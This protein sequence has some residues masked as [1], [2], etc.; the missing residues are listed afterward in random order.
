MNRRPLLLSAIGFMVLLA[1]TLILVRPDPT[2]EDAPYFTLKRRLPDTLTVAHGPDTTV[3]VPGGASGWE[4][5]RPVRYPADHLVAETMLKRLADIRVARTYPLT[6]EKMD[7]YGMRISR[8][9]IVAAYAD[10]L[11]SDTLTIGAFTLNDSY[12]YIRAGSRLE[13]GLMDARLVRSFLLKSTLEL[14]D[15]RLMPFHETRADT[16]QLLGPGASVRVTLARGAENRWELLAP[17]NAPVDQKKARNFLSSVG[18]MNIHRFVTEGE[19]GNLQDF[20]LLDPRAGARVVTRNGDV[21]SVWLGDDLPAISD[22][23][24]EI[25]VAAKSDLRPHLLGVSPKYLEVLRS[26]PEA[27]ADAAPFRFGLVSVDA[28]HLDAPG[29]SATFVW[30]DSIG[31]A[32]GIRDVFRNWIVLRAESFDR[33]SPQALARW[34]LDRPEGTLVWEGNVDTLAVVDVGVAAQ[35]LRPIR[36]RGGRHAR[37]DD[38][39]LLP[40]RQTGPLWTYILDQAARSGS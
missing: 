18:H 31:I 12:D 36:V 35:G 29:R 10:G 14:R 27:F 22:L 33:V 32:P 5:I 11:E 37:P 9:R 15:T 1:V 4:V 8:G 25:L 38:I 40:D 23:P 34:G 21:L 3:L 17:Y 16:F 26:G 6:P 24:Q 2:P 39:L 19:G 7:T 20:G 30:S 28:I 13:V